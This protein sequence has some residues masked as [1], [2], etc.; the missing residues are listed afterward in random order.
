[1]HIFKLKENPVE[2]LFFFLDWKLLFASFILNTL[3]ICA[4]LIVQWCESTSGVIRPRH[5]I[6]PSTKQKFLYWQDFYCQKW[7][8]VWGMPLMLYPTMFLY[9]YN[10]LDSWS[11]LFALLAILATRAFFK[12]CTKKTHKPDWGYPK[13]GE[14]SF[15]GTLH[16]TYFGFYIF[17]VI[18]SIYS[19]IRGYLVR[20]EI[21]VFFLGATI[22][23]A[24]WVKDVRSGNFAKLEK[25]H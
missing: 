14:H 7:G 6:I 3:A 1:M 18:T 10:C 23:I 20:E 8:N 5:H 4:M 13:P 22:Y 25:I 2:N 19:M 9:K 24:T 11:L 16:L 12:E 17:V 15:S 21:F